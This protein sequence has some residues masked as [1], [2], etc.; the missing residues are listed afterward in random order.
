[1][2]WSRA[3]ASVV[4]P[5]DRF[6]WFL[7]TVSNEVMPLSLSSDRRDD[8]HAAIQ[9]MPLGP[10]ALSA[11]EFSP[12]RAWRSARHIRQGDPE[13]YQLVLVTQGSF[14]VSQ[15]G[16]EALVA[17]DFVLSDTSSPMLTECFSAGDP[18]HA[19]T[20]QIP[21]SAL[22]LSPRK[23]EPLLVRPLPAHKGATAILAGFLRTLHAQG[24]HCGTEALLS[25][26]S[27]TVDLVTACLAQHL[28]SLDEAPVEAR[29]QLMLQRI[30]RFIEHNLG[31]PDL[32]PRTIAERHN[33]S[34]RTLYTLFDGEPASIAGVIRRR[35]L[36]RCHTDL[37]RPEM[38]HRTVQ[39]ISA[40][41]GFTNPATFSRTFRDAYGTT[42]TEH[43]AHARQHRNT[44]ATQQAER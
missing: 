2:G 18:I 22:P 29:S 28:H 5:T 42:P 3:S 34:L 40:R 17:G 10:V 15:E 7:E 36:E 44:D 43:R 21:R 4:P 38:D 20:L 14:R 35:R 16:R 39:A 32:S 23:L 30:L 41:W 33:I 13:G 11:F 37:A 26:G 1:M 24:A 6:E 9:D 12:V 19:L 8:F 25:M 27:A 31:D